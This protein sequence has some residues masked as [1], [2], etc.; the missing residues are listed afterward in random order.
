MNGY[1]ETGRRDEIA[2]FDVFFR[3]NQLIT[4]SVA[5]GLEQVVEYLTNL[6]FEKDDIEYLKS[7]NIFSQGFL[8]YLES[9]RF[10]GD[11]YS[12]REGTFVFPGEP[13]FTVVANVMEAQLIETAVLNIMNHQTLIATKAAKV[14]YAAKGDAVMEFG[15]RRAQ[16]ARRGDTRRRGSHHK[17]TGRGL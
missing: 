2:V 7:L 1:F 14:C 4:Y 13:I 5:A 11:V 15:L 10:S 9:F 3:R 16:Y 17:N 8:D 6:K 12:V